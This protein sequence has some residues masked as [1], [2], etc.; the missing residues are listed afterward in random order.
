MEILLIGGKG[1]QDCQIGGNRR[2]IVRV[3]VEDLPS[4]G[5]A[6][7]PNHGAPIRLARTYWTLENWLDP[8]REFK[9]FGVRR[10]SSNALGVVFGA[11]VLYCKNR[12]LLISACR[13]CWA[14]RS[15]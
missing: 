6:I 8:S 5:V 2:Q 15:T 12:H 14:R 7:R 9:A 11:A 10:Y 1:N 4:L 3:V 13:D